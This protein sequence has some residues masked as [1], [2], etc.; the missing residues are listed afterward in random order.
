MQNGVNRGDW[1]PRKSACGLGSMIG[2]HEITSCGFDSAAASN[3]AVGAHQ[4]VA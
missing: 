1:E 2:I 4:A 3:D